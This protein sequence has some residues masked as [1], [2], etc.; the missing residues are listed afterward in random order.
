MRRIRTTKP[1]PAQAEKRDPLTHILDYGTIKDD[2]LRSIQGYTLPAESASLLKFCAVGRSQAE[3]KWLR[4]RAHSH[5]IEDAIG[6]RVKIVLYE[7]MSFKLPGLTYTP[8][9]D[10]ILDNGRI[11]FVEIKGSTRQTNYRDARTHLR[12]AASLN[13]WFT[14][15]EAIDNHGAFELELIKPDAEFM[16]DMIKYLED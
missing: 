15:F 4:D 16:H 9:Y 3:S 11:A 7:W 14:F 6:G 8:D 10:Y 1:K 13:P 12:V 5:M 2:L